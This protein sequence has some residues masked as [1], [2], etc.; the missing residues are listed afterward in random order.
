MEFQ[1]LQLNET[2]IKTV[3]ELR[4]RNMKIF[5]KRQFQNEM[6]KNQ[7]AFDSVFGIILPVICFFF[8]PIVFRTTGYA[9]GMLGMFKPFA[10]LLSYFSIMSL[11]AFLL[12]GAK[13]KWL[14]GFLS[15]LFAVGA[16]ISFGI[17]VFLFPFSVIGL[18][19]LIG[20]LGFTPLFTS[21]VYARNSVRAYRNAKPF[22]K[23]KLLFNSIALSA[24]LSLSLPILVNRKIETGLQ[25]MRNSDA[26]TVRATARRLKFVAPLIDVK[27]LNWSSCGQE[28]SP[29]A[30]AMIEAYQDLDGKHDENY[31]LVCGY[32]QD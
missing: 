32:S 20:A 6:T 31:F 14:N 30:Q 12:W 7:K 25:T 23:P 15:G 5:W 22:A 8:D 26:Q 2:Q 17:G 3:G 1:T 4:K 13:L 19:I 27:R 18:I 24:I 16:A 9:E 29:K 10:Y 11:L 28:N 21:F